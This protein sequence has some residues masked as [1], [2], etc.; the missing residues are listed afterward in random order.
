MFPSSWLFYT[1]QNR[2]GMTDVVRQ[3]QKDLQMRR[4]MLHAAGVTDEPIKCE[5]VGEVGDG[6]GRL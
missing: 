6:K 5:S 3:G 1:S 2:A 4:G